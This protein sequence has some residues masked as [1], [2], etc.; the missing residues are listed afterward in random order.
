[1]PIRLVPSV[2]IS[3]WTRK[4]PTPMPLA[5]PIS[6][7]RQH[8]EQR[9]PPP[10]PGCTTCVAMMKALIVATVPTDRSMPPVSMVMV[11]QPAS[12][13]SGMA[14]LH[15]VGDPALV[16]DA[17]AQD[18]QDDHQ[19]DQQE[20]QRDQRLVAHQP[21]EAAA[22]GDGLGGLC[23]LWLMSAALMARK[24]PNIT[25]TTMIVPSMMVVTL[26]S[27]ASSVRSVRTRRS[28]KTATI[29]PTQPA[30]AA[31]ERHAAEHDGGDAGEQIGAGDR[32]ADAGAHGQRQAAHARRTGR[33][34]H[35]R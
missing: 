29:G 6:T 14:N 11:W 24:A 28:T 26:G 32:R 27:M 8:G 25:T 21:L 22:E 4:T 31:A 30:P 3:G 19:D 15:G 13:A 7:R 34:G 35:R 10:G 33:R 18:L 23:R 12:S 17:G 20:D 2:M 5:R 9:A 1:M 16:D